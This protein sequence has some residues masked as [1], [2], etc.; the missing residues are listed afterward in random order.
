MRQVE[1]TACLNPD[2]SRTEP[3]LTPSRLTHPRVD[4]GRHPPS[5][6]LPHR[7]LPQLGGAQDWQLQ[8]GGPLLSTPRPI[9]RL[10]MKVGCHYL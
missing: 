7:A 5:D 2:T 4:L 9:F 10:E 1:G 3:R 6:P 8:G